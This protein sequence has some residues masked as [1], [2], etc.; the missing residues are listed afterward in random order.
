MSNTLTRASRGYKLTV[1]HFNSRDEIIPYLDEK[2]YMKAPDGSEVTLCW[3]WG[4]GDWK[5]ENKVLEL[6]RA[7]GSGNSIM[8]DFIGLLESIR[9]LEGIPSLAHSKTLGNR[10]LLSGN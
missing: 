10:W 3:A 1:K 8:W 7:Y 2:G 9:H 5:D 6:H 4:G